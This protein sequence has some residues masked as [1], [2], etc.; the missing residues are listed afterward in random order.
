MAAL[1]FTSAAQ[2]QKPDRRS[3]TAATATVTPPMKAIVYCDYGSPEVLRL[4]GI[5]KL[6]PMTIKYWFGTP[7][8][9]GSYQANFS[10]KM[11]TGKR[12]FS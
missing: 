10:A 11:A 6:F 5:E 8:A 7:A 12:D 9:A 4:E 2:T 3:Q 1:L